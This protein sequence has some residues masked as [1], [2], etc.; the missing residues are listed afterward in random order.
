MYFEP[1]NLEKSLIKYPQYVYHITSIDNDK[2]IR[3]Y[4]I[5]PKSETKD[6]TYPDRVYLFTE[7]DK[8]A[9]INHI[10][11]SGKLNTN[12]PGWPAIIYKIKP[13]NNIFCRYSSIRL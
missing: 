7:Y 5:I 6:L 4:G 13:N 8:H 11:A 10:R 3:K 9:M 12:I 2:S 1:Y